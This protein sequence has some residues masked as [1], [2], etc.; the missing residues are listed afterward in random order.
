VQGTPEQGLLYDVRPA[1]PM[2]L[3]AVAVILGCVVA[4]ASLVPARR[5]TA[6]GALT[7]PRQENG[8]WDFVA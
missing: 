2:V 1:D 5:A 4:A 7:R 6:G 8:W 3:A